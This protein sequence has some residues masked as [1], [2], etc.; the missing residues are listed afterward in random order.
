MFKYLLPFV[1]VAGLAILSV[2]A[3]DREW[4]ND[5]QAKT[6]KQARFANS[7]DECRS[8]EYFDPRFGICVKMREFTTE[9]KL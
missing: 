6:G 9:D 8:T 1:I 4:L 2:E 3:M 5:Y 7:D